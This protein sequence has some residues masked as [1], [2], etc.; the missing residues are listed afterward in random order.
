MS[1]RLHITSPIQL[2][3][4]NMAGGGGGALQR[5]KA[6]FKHDHPPTSQIVWDSRCGCDVS[7]VWEAHKLVT[8]L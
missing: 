3:V 6:D 1:P 2:A 7:S 8:Q 4:G 5:L